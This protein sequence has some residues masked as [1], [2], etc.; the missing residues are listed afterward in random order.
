VNVVLS[1]D[2]LKEI[3]TA[4]SKITVHGSRLPEEIL[5]LSYR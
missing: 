3:E 1:G 5:K 4:A 2:D